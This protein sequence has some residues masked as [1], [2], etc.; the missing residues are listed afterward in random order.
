MK[1]ANYGQYAIDFYL[2]YLND[3]LTVA[4]IAEAHNISEQSANG[5]IARGRTLYSKNA[6]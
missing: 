6:A 5:L 4:K 1:K 2:E 3:Y